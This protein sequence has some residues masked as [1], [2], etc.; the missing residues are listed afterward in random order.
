MPSVRSGEELG[1]GSK[2]GMGVVLEPTVPMVVCV[3]AAPGISHGGERGLGRALRPGGSGG[4]NGAARCPGG[5]DLASE[6]MD[7]RSSS[8]L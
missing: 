7:T 5:L 4:R 2:D 8:S 3:V 1:L 6:I